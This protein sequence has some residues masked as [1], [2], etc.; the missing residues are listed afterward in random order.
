MSSNI[1]YQ[2]QFTKIPSRTSLPFLSDQNT[3]L[4]NVAKKM[5]ANVSTFSIVRLFPSV[6]ILDGPTQDTKLVALWRTIA[7]Q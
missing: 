4:Q 3:I 7:K 2:I 6:K 1:P 5:D